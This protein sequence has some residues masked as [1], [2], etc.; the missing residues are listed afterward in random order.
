MSVRKSFSSEIAEIAAELNIPKA[1]VERV[2]RT[3]LAHQVAALKRGESIC[4]EGLF[5]IKVCYNASD[6]KY[7][8]RG[9]VSPALKHLLDG[10]SEQL[11][12][13]SGMDT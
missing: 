6:K 3:R 9:A 8:Y 12:L 1:T 4:E 10:N 13:L 2:L 11:R 7:S 5:T